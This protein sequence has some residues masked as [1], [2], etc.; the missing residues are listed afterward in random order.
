V[1]CCGTT[2][3]R[4]ALPMLLRGRY[5]LGMRVNN[6][7]DVDN[8]TYLIRLQKPDCKATLLL[9]SG[10]RIHTTEFEWPKNMMPSSFAMKCRKHL[11]T[12]RLVSVNQLGIDRIVD[13][14]F[15]SDEAAYHLIIELY[16]RGNIVLTDHEYTILNILRFRTDEADDVRFAVRE[17]YPVDSAKA[18]ASLPTLERLTEIISNASKGEQLK[19]VLN[20]HLRK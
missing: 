1:M 9:E 2:G 8:K 11:K 18:P 3:Q 7:Y 4:R 13:F 20:P 14:Q 10:I 15:G 16:D 12:R 19:R 6:V 5:L 17:R